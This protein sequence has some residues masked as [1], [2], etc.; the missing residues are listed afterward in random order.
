MGKSTSIKQLEQQ[1]DEYRAY[2][3]KIETELA[4]SADKYDTTMQKDIN[5]Y[6][7]D[8]NWTAQ[9]FISGK[10]TDFMQQADWSMKNVKTIIDAV[11]SAVFGNT[12]APEG[13]T[14]EKAEEVGKAVAEMANWELY[15]AGKIFEVLSGIVESFGSA[16]SV[17]FNS[18]YKSEKLGNGMHLFA[19]VVCDSYKSTSFFENKEI[20]EYL[21]IYQ[22]KYSAQEAEQDADLI[23]TKLY[24]DAIQTFSDK[25]EDL[26]KKLETDEITGEQYSSQSE[27]FNHLIDQYKKK[28]IALEST[29]GQ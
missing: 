20:Y 14:I 15:V 1:E 3:Q 16:S 29:G 9:N 24:E 28:L 11:S 19:T 27:I 5:D 21:Y 2:L 23:L 25:V 13:V 6:Y 7:K 8:N 4:T 17:S 22:V 12:K 18:S 10:N 26:L